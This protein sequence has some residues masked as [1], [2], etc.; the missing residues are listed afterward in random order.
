M[1]QFYP[2]PNSGVTLHVNAQLI[3]YN[4]TQQ[5]FV[6]HPLQADRGT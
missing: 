5:L 2:A 6:L 3:Q 1:L 4:T